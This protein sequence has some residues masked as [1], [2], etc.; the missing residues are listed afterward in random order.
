MSAISWV[1]VKDFTVDAVEKQLEEYIQTW[2]MQRCW[3]YTLDFLSST[4][5]EHRTFYHYRARFGVPTAGEPLPGTASVRFDV[6]VSRVKPASVPVE[7][8]FVVESS[9]LVHTPAGT[10]FRE[11]WLEDVVESKTLLRREAGL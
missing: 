3:L 8:S 4:E 2:E 7:V 1:A 10:R 11:K 6:C 9:R 5:E